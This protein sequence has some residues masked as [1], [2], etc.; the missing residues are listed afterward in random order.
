V[1]ALRSWQHIEGTTKKRK[2]GFRF[3]VSLNSQEKEV[4]KKQKKF[5][6]KQ[7]PLFCLTLRRLFAFSWPEQSYFPKSKK[8][9]SK[10]H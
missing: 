8:K 5:E 9:E 4:E 7:K 1:A 6:K 3:F 10:L 2:A